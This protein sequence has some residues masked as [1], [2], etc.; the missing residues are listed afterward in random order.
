MFSGLALPAMVVAMS[1]CEQENCRASLAMS[2][3]RWAQ[4][5][6]AARAA[7]FTASGSLSQAGKE[8]LVSRRALK[9]P[10]FM[11]PIPRAFR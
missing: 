2:D 1:G 4:S 11:A 10:A 6:A 7:A 9:G 5:A 3:P 8:A